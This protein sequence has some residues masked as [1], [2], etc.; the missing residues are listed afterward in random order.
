M[1]AEYVHPTVLVAVLI[2]LAVLTNFTTAQRI[3]HVGRLFQERA[4]R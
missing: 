3:R 2:A 1:L 4:R